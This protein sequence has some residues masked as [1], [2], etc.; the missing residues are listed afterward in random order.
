[1]RNLIERAQSW[2][3]KDVEFSRFLILAVQFS[4][5]LLG[6]FYSSLHLLL[7]NGSVN[8]FHFQTRELVEDLFVLDP[9][10]VANSVAKNTK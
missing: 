8:L 4:L 9:S 1:M 6:Q 3:Q 10:V 5:F 7:C 2:E